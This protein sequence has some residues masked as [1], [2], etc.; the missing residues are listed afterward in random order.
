MELQRSHPEWVR[1][2]KPASRRITT[3][4][5][6]SHPEWVRGLKLDA[7]Q[8]LDIIGGSHPEWVR[9]LKLLNRLTICINLSR[10]PSG[11]VD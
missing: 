5:P 11:C 2:L 4:P 6:A 3:L 9:G 8:Q 1:G 7:K 10:T